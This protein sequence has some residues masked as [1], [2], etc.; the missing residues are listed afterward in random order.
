MIS[1]SN[2]VI[3]KV[4]VHKTKKK[5]YIG[6]NFDINDTLGTRIVLDVIVTVIKA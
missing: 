4:K 2:L 6:I 5:Q 3:K 1:Q